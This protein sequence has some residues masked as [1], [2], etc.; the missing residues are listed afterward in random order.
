[1]MSLEFYISG[2]K[3]FGSRSQKET[4]STCN[5]SNW[6][7][8]PIFKLELEFSSAVT[9]AAEAVPSRITNSRPLTPLES[10]S[11]TTIVSKSC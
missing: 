7:K 5:C 4:A 1:M 8:H 9:K 11:P 6:V 3:D 10:K 2:L